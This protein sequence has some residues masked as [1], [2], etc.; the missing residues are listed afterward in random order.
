[1]DQAERDTEIKKLAQACHDIMHGASEPGTV[2]VSPY[3]SDATKFFGMMHPDE[4][5][6]Q[7]PA[8]IEEPPPEEPPP[9][10]EAEAA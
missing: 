5:A 2:D 8:P 7:P 10:A 4:V 9:E 3:M 6:W 1:M